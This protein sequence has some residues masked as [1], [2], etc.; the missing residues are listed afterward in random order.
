[1][2]ILAGVTL[3]IDQNGIIRKAEQGAADYQNASETEEIEMEKLLNNFVEIETIGK[4]NSVFS[5]ALDAANG[6]IKSVTASNIQIAL[7][8][9]DENAI[10]WKDYDDESALIDNGHRTR[11]IITTNWNTGYHP[12]LFCRIYL[13]EKNITTG[14]IRTKYSKIYS[15]KI[16]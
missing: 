9:Y 15:Y 14:E 5:N 13:T 16:K 12:G 3:N 1:L 6:D 4:L 8:E 11:W 10:V 2:I 7:N